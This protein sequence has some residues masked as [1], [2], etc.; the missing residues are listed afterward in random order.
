MRT[1]LPPLPPIEDYYWEKLAIG[2]KEHRI[3]W[4]K[5]EWLGDRVLMV[6]VLKFANRRFIKETEIRLIRD[7]SIMMVT[8]KILAAYS[9]TLKLDQLNKMNLPIV[10]KIHA[11][12]FEAY[13]G[14]FYLAY[15]E[16]ATTNYLEKLMGP[17]FDMLFFAD[18]NIS[19]IKLAAAYFS[20]PWL[21]TLRNFP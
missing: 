5:L 17:L 16:E 2:F 11:D 7:I 15:G 6:S 1:D 14:A 3:H 9:L 13:F 18:S 21:V 12:A 19:K 8:N 20:M 4:E 10:K